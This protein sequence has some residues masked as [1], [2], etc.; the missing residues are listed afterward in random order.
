MDIYHLMQNRIGVFSFEFTKLE[1][2][3]MK[4]VVV[5]ATCR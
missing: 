5:I 4:T 2:T 3:V 1:H